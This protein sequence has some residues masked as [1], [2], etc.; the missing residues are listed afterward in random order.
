[1]LISVHM[2]RQWATLIT[3]LLNEAQDGLFAAVVSKLSLLQQAGQQ[4]L[5]FLRECRR[6]NSQSLVSSCQGP[7]KARARYEANRSVMLDWFHR[8]KPSCSQSK[9]HNRELLL[10][11]VICG[12]LCC[13]D[14][15]D[16][17]IPAIYIHFFPYISLTGCFRL[18]HNVLGNNLITQFQIS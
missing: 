7:G 9:V 4:S 14:H 2:T 18:F 6:L 16:A 1:M 17:E 10:Y 8:F 5:V 11:L 12:H 3:C 15:F 13:R